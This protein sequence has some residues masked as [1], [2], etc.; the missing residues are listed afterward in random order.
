MEQS[1]PSTAV[2]TQPGGYAVAPHR[3]FSPAEIK[4]KLAMVSELLRD[5]MVKDVDYGIIPGTKDNSLWKPGGELIRMLFGFEVEYDVQQE[6]DATIN[7]L[8][9]TTTC[10]LR[11]ESGAVVGMCIGNANSHETKYHYH[12]V[13]EADVPDTVD[14]ARC[15]T[16]M[17]WANRVQVKHYQV[18]NTAPFALLNTLVKISEKRAFL[19]AI[20]VATACSRIFKVIETE[21][22]DYDHQPAAA[23]GAPAQRQTQQRQAPAPARKPAAPTS[24]ARPPVTR[25][26]PPEFPPDG[27]EDAPA[28]APAQAQSPA[29]PPPAEVVAPE[30]PGPCTSLEQAFAHIQRIFG[31]SKA[32][33]LKEYGVKDVTGIAETPMQ[34]YTRMRAI[35]QPLPYPLKG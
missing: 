13:V 35:Y 27:L 12:W 7:L 32:T 34:V 4:V 19:G 1:T 11:D 8:S 25:A 2:V 10:R 24:Q 20:Q 28:P 14:K 29:Q 15:V 31:V 16:S 5:V 18:E 23:A 30:N 26:D 17:R 9:L 33:V 22:D 3:A 21:E 6:Y